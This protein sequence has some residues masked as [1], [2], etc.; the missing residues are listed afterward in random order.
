MLHCN[1]MTK[2]Y[3][4]ILCCQWV[5]DCGYGFVY[6]YKTVAYCHN[7]CCCLVI[8]HCNI[9]VNFRAIGSS[10]GQ[11]KASSSPWTLAELD[12]DIYQHAGTKLEPRGDAWAQYWCDL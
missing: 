6:R 7:A 12:V 3:V 5:S 11:S 1:N 10:S 8:V 2:L 4:P 9:T